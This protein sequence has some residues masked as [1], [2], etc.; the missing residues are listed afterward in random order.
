M[1]WRAVDFE[2]DGG[3]LAGSLEP[4]DP[5]V[6][7]QV[8]DQ[9]RAVGGQGDPVRT[10]VHRR[11]GAPRL[12]PAIAVNDRDAARPFRHEDVT[13]AGGEDALGAVQAGAVR[14]QRGQWNTAIA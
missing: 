6:V 12:C 13:V 3:K 11:R 7:A 14:F 10:Q 8:R 9:E 2:E 5:S 1:A 4:P